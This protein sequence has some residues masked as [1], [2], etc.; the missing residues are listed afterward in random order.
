[1]KPGW[2]K[3]TLG[4]VCELRYGKA[5][6]ESDRTG[7]GRPVF[8]SNGIVGHHSKTLTDGPTIVVGRKGSHGE[9]T[10]SAEACWPIDTT[11]FV[12]SSCTSADLKWLYH[13][14][15]SL[16]LNQLNRAAAVPGL[17]REDAYRKELLLPPTEE[18]RRIA[19][20]LDAAAALRSKRREAIEKL[21]ALSQSIF[22]EMFGGP[23]SNPYSYAVRELIEIIDPQR[24]IT[25]GI[26]KPGEDT[27]GGVPYVRVVDMVEGG[28]AVDG[29]RRTTP[30]I[31]AAYRRSLLAED[32]LIMSIRG[33]VGRLALVDKR[34]QGANIT[35]DT[36]RLAI[37][38]AN[39]VYVLECL[40][41]TEMQRWMAAFT[42]G[43]AVKG[44]NLTDVKRMPIPLPPRDLQDR[45]AVRAGAA[46]QLRRDA[47]S[48]LP[49][50]DA[51]FASLQHRAFQGEL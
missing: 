49:T 16:G 38:G 29:L 9:V 43:A 5:L 25:Y 47:R 27:A 8:G 20:I 19:S 41:S 2:K 13:C 15:S 44:I 24:P 36:A 50:S 42:K 34:A 23:M 1:M 46:A 21:D 12:D 10:Y 30:E 6:K 22:V 14:M 18:Q 48:A 31:S 11:Y 40:R 45:F 51:L 32:D 3:M 37:T 7:G 4:Q 39:P 17:N 35:Q 33:H 28:I 26:L